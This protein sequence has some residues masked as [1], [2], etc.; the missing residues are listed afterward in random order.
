M[1]TLAKNP[2]HIE[3]W[4]SSEV[5][6]GMVVLTDSDAVLS[7]VVERHL[8]IRVE[9]LASPKFDA[10]ATGFVE[11]V[12]DNQT[13]ITRGRRCSEHLLAVLKDVSWKAIPLS[14]LSFHTP[15]FQSHTVQQ[16]KHTAEAHAKSGVKGRHFKIQAAELC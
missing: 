8:S 16:N 3:R 11:E 12:K 13:M 6:P 7:C 4:E 2:T 10:V 15:T 5:K 1:M 14:L 9:E